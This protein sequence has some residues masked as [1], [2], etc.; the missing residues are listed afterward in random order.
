VLQSAERRPGKRTRDGAEAGNMRGKV[1]G[2][3]GPAPEIPTSTPGSQ[4]S[5]FYVPH[6]KLP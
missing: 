2:I 4:P 6:F 5:T 3:G 1:D